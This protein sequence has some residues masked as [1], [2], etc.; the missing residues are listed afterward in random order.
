MQM[1]IR[2]ICDSNLTSIQLVLKNQN[3]E[4]LDRIKQIFA[5]RSLEKL[6]RMNVTTHVL[7]ADWWQSAREEI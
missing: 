1:M 2:K 4:E 6:L 3:D 7:C 5:S